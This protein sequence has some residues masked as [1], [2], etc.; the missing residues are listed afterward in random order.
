MGGYYMSRCSFLS[1]SHNKVSCF[2]ECP[3][4][5]YDDN[6]GA[7]PFECFEGGRTWKSK[8]SYDDLFKSEGFNILEELYQENKYLNIFQI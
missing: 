2:N 3:F 7:C 1:T 4:Y 6:N 8:S 5:N